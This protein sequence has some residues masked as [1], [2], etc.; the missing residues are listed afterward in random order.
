MWSHL[1]LSPVSALWGTVEN[2][3]VHLLSEMASQPPG[4]LVFPLATHLGR[5][6]S[7]Y[8][9]AGGF[10]RPSTGK[11]APLAYLICPPTGEGPFPILT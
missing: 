5:K 2:T 7:P 4:P 9:G 1:Q 8:Q 11:V 6:L 3:T 10:S